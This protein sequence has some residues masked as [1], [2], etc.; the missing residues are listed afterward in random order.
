MKLKQATTEPMY[1]RNR[2]IAVEA[3]GTMNETWVS[4]ESDFWH[5]ERVGMSIFLWVPS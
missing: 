4:A 5:G 2:T 1:W 3:L